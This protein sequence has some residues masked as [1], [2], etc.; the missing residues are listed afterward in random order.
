MSSRKDENNLYDWSIDVEH[1]VDELNS[2]PFREYVS[3][4]VPF[5]FHGLEDKLDNRSARSFCM[6]RLLVKMLGVWKEICCVKDPSLFR[7]VY[8][9]VTEPNMFGSEVGC[10]FSAEK[11]ESL[12]S[13]NVNI[14]FFYEKIKEIKPQKIPP[15]GIIT[16]DFVK[17]S[18]FSHEV[19]DEYEELDFNGGFHL[20]WV[21]E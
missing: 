16:P 2:R 18:Y 21:E 12:R 8:C 15:H 13:R 17:Y 19:R 9:L 11:W 6:E 20:F 4:N 7:V 14:P 1:V 3:W 5:P 10:A